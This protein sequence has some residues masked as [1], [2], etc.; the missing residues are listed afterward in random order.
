MGFQGLITH[1][2]NNTKPQHNNVIKNT[3]TAGLIRNGT[4]YFPYTSEEDYHNSSYLAN[5]V[6]P[7]VYQRITFVE[8]LVNF[9]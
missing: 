6:P 7:F 4:E 3:N 1:F 8:E 2:S 9:V 5:H